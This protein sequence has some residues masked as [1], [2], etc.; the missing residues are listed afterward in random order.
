MGLLAEVFLTIVVMRV[1][2]TEGPNMSKIVTKTKL[3]GF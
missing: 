3:T 1:I 2:C